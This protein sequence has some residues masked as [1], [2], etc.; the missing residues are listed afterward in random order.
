MQIPISSCRVFKAIA[1]CGLA[2]ALAGCGA[3]AADDIETSQSALCDG[4]PC[5]HWGPP[6]LN[7]D[8]D[9]TWNPGPPRPGTVRVWTEPNFDGWCTALGPGRTS[10]LHSWGLG[11]RIR[12]FHVGEGVGLILHRDVDFRGQAVF[13]PP[14]TKHGCVDRSCQQFCLAPCPRGGCCG[15]QKYQPTAS[16]LVVTTP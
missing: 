5:V 4:L 1:I 3:E 15:W 10:N 12:S 11:D 16:S 13:Y 9:C 14:N 7:G 2:G 6:P 8:A